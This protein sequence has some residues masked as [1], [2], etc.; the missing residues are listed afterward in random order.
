M[1][2]TSPQAEIPE[3]KNNKFINNLSTFNLSI[4]DSSF[5]DSAS[6][7]INSN[8]K[9]NI[10]C[11]IDKGYSYGVMPI[12]SISQSSSISPIQG[13]N[14]IQVIASDIAKN[15]DTTNFEFI[16]DNTAPTININYPKKDSIYYKPRVNLDVLVSDLYLDAGKSYLQLNSGSKIYLNSTLPD[17]LT[18]NK[19]SNNLYVYAVDSAGNTSTK[20]INFNY[21]D[22]TQLITEQRGEKV[23]CSIYPNPAQ[24]R[25]TLSTVCTRP[26]QSISVNIYNM[27]GINVC[28][29]IL[30][31]VAGLNT[32]IIDLTGLTPGVYYVTLTTGDDYLYNK[33]IVK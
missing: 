16:Y 32:T 24:G 11:Y 30:S 27:Q 8:L 5:L 6:Y 10:N 18:L 26:Y 15:K 28:R 2:K 4:N 17:S 13:K 31:L 1:D 9:Q 22:T 25:T 20:N 14:T 19:G 7:K 12:Y 29:H 3:L 21:T 33:L 23:T